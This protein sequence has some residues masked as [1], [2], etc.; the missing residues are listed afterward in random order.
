MN[1]PI[2]IAPQK[3][4]S[5]SPWEKCR[6]PM[7]SLAPST[8]TGSKIREP[9]VRFL[10]SWLPPFSRGGAV[11]AAS[12]ATRSKSAPLRLPRIAESGSGGRASRGGGPNQAGVHEARERH[13]GDVRGRPP[14]AAEVPDHLVGVGEL[15]GEEPAA[16]LRR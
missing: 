3:V 15:L 5:P 10:M 13:A 4:I 11:R 2:S 14:P 9:L 1:P 12:A 7:D 6:S 8:N 16:V